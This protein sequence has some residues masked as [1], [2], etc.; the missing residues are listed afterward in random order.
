MAQKLG[1]AQVG[2]SSCVYLVAYLAVSRQDFLSTAVK[3]DC[4]G[5]RTETPTSD[6]NLGTGTI[7]PVFPNP[8]SC[9]VRSAF[10]SP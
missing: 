1:A 2:L 7:S 8:C 5:T 9:K 10:R 6:Y 3:S 4:S